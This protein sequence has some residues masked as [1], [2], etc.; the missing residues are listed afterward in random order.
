[1]AEI[2]TV[3]V[4]RRDGAIEVSGDKEW[5]EKKLAELAEV[6]TT[7]LANVQGESE[8]GTTRK[9]TSRSRPPSP[10]EDDGPAPIDEE[11]FF[12][13]LATE[14]GVDEK[15]LRDVLT[16]SG[17]SVLVTPA[18]RQLGSST[19]EQAKTVIPL[20]AS[21][22]CFGLG[23]RPVDAK[24]VRAE[25]ARKNCYQERKF[26]ERHL[27]PLRGF[28][29]GANSQQIVTTSRWVEEFTAAVNRALGRPEKDDKRL[30]R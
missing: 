25:L 23:E 16:L 17:D 15:D 1:M 28:N 9:R 24:A 2:Y 8:G 12:A 4:N 6:L 11:T 30:S 19:A 27:G 3:K 10:A 13:Q 7:P 18:T 26:A 14:S 29:A 20:V 22:R 21:A 5:V